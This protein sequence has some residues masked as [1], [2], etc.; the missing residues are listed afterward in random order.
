MATDALDSGQEA[1]TVGMRRLVFIPPPHTKS[2]T[3]CTASTWT[4]D[5]AGCG[6]W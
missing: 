2:K 4:L 6:G 1:A 5:P 3:V